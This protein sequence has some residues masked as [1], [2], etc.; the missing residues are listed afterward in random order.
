MKG[1]DAQVLPPVLQCLFEEHR[2]L[3]ALTR[4]LTEK[5]SG[6]GT[7]S[8]GD[9]YLLRDVVGYLHD[10]P[11]EVHH[12]TENMLFE[13]VVRRD[14]TMQGAADRLR[15]DH[16]EIAAETAGIL[17]LLDRLIATPGGKLDAEARQA[18]LNFARRQRAHMRF[19]NNE[20]FPVAIE[21]LPRSDWRR[22]ERHFATVDDPLFGRAVARRHRL[23]YEY[24]TGPAD[25]AEQ[26]LAGLQ[27]AGLERFMQT[28][29][30]I[31][32]GFRSGFARIGDLGDEIADETRSAWAQIARPGSFG[33]AL[34]LPVRYS[35]SLGGSL[36]ECGND[37]ARICLD[38]V[39]S[40]VKALGN[41][42]TMH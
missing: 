1:P 38:T 41:S 40:T 8:P 30:V 19:E 3:S 16:D 21:S 35:L 15:R 25:R 32:D 36:L 12:P 27:M 14:P 24:L 42:K 22:I 9:C 18:C 28:S 11:D 6:P 33:A 5:V 17:E 39:S 26:G 10:Y 29:A 34:T 2:H 23:L 37:L 20:V 31:E 13:A 7:L 4:L